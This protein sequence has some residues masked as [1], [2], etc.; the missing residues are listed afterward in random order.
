MTEWLLGRP[1][2]VAVR[3]CTPADNA[4]SRRTLG[5]ND[6]ALAGY[7]EQGQAIYERRA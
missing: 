2:I 4:A 7:D 5:K 3:T 6:F 1:G